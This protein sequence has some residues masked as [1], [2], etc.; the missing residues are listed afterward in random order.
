MEAVRI[1]FIQ[2]NRGEHLIHCRQNLARAPLVYRF[3][4]AEEAVRPCMICL[5]RTRLH[6][7]NRGASG[8]E[9][10]SVREAVEEKIGKVIG[11]EQKV[12]VLR[13]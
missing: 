1:L 12:T 5:D 4:C 8:Q 11:H 7:D 13:I 3:A 9:L 6:H 10:H 2:W